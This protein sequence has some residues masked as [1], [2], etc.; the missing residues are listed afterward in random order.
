MAS[1]IGAMV[2]NECLLPAVKAV[3]AFD[4]WNE[5]IQK[6]PGETENLSVTISS[7]EDH[8]SKNPSEKDSI[9]TE[10]LIKGK[11]LA[12]RCV[13]VP[14]WNVVLKIWLL[15]DV[16]DVQNYLKDHLPPGDHS[17]S[18][19][20]A[21]SSSGSRDHPQISFRDDLSVD[22]YSY[23]NGIGKTSEK[24]DLELL[25]Q[26]K[27]SQ[28]SDEHMIFGKSYLFHASGKVIKESLVLLDT[29]DKEKPEHHKKEMEFVEV[30]EK[31]S[32]ISNPYVVPVRA[33]YFSKIDEQRL[34]MYD[35]YWKD[36]VHHMLHD[37]GSSFLDWDAR[38]K[39]ATSV[40]KGIA[41]IHAQKLVHGNIK[42]A[43]IFLNDQDEG[44]ISD[45]GQSKLFPTVPQFDRNAHKHLDPEVDDFT[46]ITPKSDIYSYG[47]LLLE[48]LFGEI[49]VSLPKTKGADSIKDHNLALLFRNNQVQW[50]NMR[51]IA[52]K[53]TKEARER[54]IDINKV[55]RRLGSLDSL[56]E[57]TN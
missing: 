57:L 6:F 24:F 9:L 36:S 45:L 4:Y 23:G 5:Q 19:Y 2:L 38:V 37:K 18:S 49:D 34:V 3:F 43:N 39:M 56:K 33:Y 22:K 1:M 52:K 55:L 40:A 47:T 54:K 12:E 48:L 50:K 21:A 30:M 14:W 17:S 26:T 35:Y 11:D 16:M 46:Q 20:A 32:R 29:V 44:C 25:L 15:N 13:N 31:V 8:M 42:S 41:H 7:I 53:C 28:L 27:P 10:K 51:K